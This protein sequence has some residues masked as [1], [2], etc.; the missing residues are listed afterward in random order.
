MSLVRLRYIGDNGICPRDIWERLS[1]LFK[2]SVLFIVEQMIKVR[3]LFDVKKVLAGMDSMAKFKLAGADEGGKIWEPMV[4]KAFKYMAKELSIITG[5]Q[6]KSR[7]LK[8]RQIPVRDV[9]AVFGGS[10]ALTIGVCSN[11]FGDTNGRFLLACNTELV[12][13]L[14][15]EMAGTGKLTDQSLLHTEASALEELCGGIASSFLQAAADFVDKQFQCLPP[16]VLIDA[17]TA[18]VDIALSEVLEDIEYA[19]IADVIFIADEYEATSTFMIAACPELTEL[20]IAKTSRF[21]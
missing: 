5:K 8:L 19:L 13:V 3:H 2:S 15:G 6:V 4:T 20:V 7:S 18:I 21:A 9:P 17:S 10:G 11:Y 12:C 14:A 16:T 1:I